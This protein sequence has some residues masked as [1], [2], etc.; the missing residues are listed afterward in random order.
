MNTRLLTEQE[1]TKRKER[2][3]LHRIEEYA[4]KFLVDHS[5]NAVVN[6]ETLEKAFVNCV[7]PAQKTLYPAIKK[8]IEEMRIDSQYKF[9]DDE[10]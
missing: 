4:I 8:R 10:N 7:I 3:M 1:I 2:T 9:C 6:D 5:R